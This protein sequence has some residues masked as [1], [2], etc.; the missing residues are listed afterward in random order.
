MMTASRSAGSATGRASASASDGH[1][2]ASGL[3]DVQRRNYMHCRSSQI[4]EQGSGGGGATGNSSS[5]RSVGTGRVGGR[6]W[7][8]L[9]III[10][11][12][13]LV[14]HAVWYLFFYVCTS[15]SRYVLPL[16]EER[17][18]VWQ[19]T[20]WPADADAVALPCFALFAEM[21]WFPQSGPNGR[22]HHPEV[23]RGGNEELHLWPHL[24]SDLMTS[25]FGHFSLSSNS[26]SCLLPPA[27]AS[28]LAFCLAPLARPPAP[29][30][31]PSSGPEAEAG[32]IFGRV[33]YHAPDDAQSEA[34]AESR[35]SGQGGLL[36]SGRQ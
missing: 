13:L 35:T 25:S 19:G 12:R 20:T 9:R 7:N 33:G 8:L 23:R 1:G 32:G 30:H 6:C 36:R 5:C 24:T 4:T 18:L 26:A 29:D 27:L 28:C 21:S 22:N 11:V 3:G 16:C 2:S 14:G 10:F 31:G 34:E 17:W 15:E